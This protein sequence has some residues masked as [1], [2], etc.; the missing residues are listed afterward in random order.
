MRTGQYKTINASVVH[1]GE[2]EDIDFITGEIIRGKRVSDQVI[3]YIAYFKLVNGFEKTLYMT[4]AEVEAHA[5]QFSQAY[6]ADK[7]YGKS[8][9]VWT[10]NFDAMALKTVLK[11]LISKYGIMSIDMQGGENIARAIESDGAVIGQDGTPSY[12]ENEPQNITPVEPQDF[13][14]AM[15][16]AGR[17]DL[18]LEER[19]EHE[20]G[21]QKL[22]GMDT[23]QTTPAEK[24]EKAEPVLEFDPGEPEF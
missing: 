24:Q 4:K 9:S 11:R 20:A 23:E 2:I 8:R 13:D 5:V 22:A 14:T 19:L 12:V 1:E 7:R 17:E 15:E 10:T 18:P 6:G 3:G 16:E 21:Q